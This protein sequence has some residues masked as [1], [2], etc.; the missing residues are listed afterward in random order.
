MNFPANPSPGQMDA[1]AM[2]V[3]VNWLVPPLILMIGIALGYVFRAILL[4]AGAR[5][6]SDRARQIV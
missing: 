1:D 4:R 6:A 5:R 2:V 3:V